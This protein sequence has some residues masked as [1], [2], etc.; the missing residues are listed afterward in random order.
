[1]CNQVVSVF[2]ACGI[3]IP[4]KKEL[5]FLTCKTWRASV[6]ISL[7]YDKTFIQ[8]LGDRTVLAI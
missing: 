5:P 1:M 7:G 3:Y 8:Q 6:A 2:S 4:A